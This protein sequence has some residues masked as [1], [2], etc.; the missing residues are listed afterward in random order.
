M[1]RIL[2]VLLYSVSLGCL[3]V[4]TQTTEHLPLTAE[5]RPE[6]SARQALIEMF[7]GKG[8]DD[9]TKH[10]PEDARHTLIRKGEL[11]ETSWVLR[12]ADA[13]RQISAQGE[14]VET[15]DTGPNILVGQSNG[16]EKFEVT[17]EHDSLLG[18]ADEIELSFHLY[19]NGQP[20][21]LPVVPR[22]TFTMQK[23]KDIW[24]LTEVTAAAHVPLTDADYLKSLR[25]QQDETNEGAAQMRL[26]MMSIAEKGYATNHADRGYT[27]SLSALF[28]PDPSTPQGGNFY[29]PGQ[30]N[31][32][33][34]GYR[35]AISGCEGSPASK[36]RL[37]A[38]PSDP[39]SK[40]KTFC[41]DESGTIRFVKSGKPS[42]CFTRGQA[43]NS[44]EP[45][46][47]SD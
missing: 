4:F 27:C 29:D 8:A 14:H 22:L 10:L 30:G 2:V 9:F 19:K 44:E 25:Q 11:P 35:F 33:W 3:P 6:Q 39:D 21:P 47:V 28:T 37:I 36:Y 15:F 7:F 17:V 13:G 24:R 5:P 20:Q 46:S 43:A 34:N 45:A 32:E 1:R 31:E 23:E 38:V 26:T 18:E 41:A 16:T 42:S 12:I 40:M